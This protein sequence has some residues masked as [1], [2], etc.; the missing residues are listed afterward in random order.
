M[1][2]NDSPT[3]TLITQG[4]GAIRK[5]PNYTVPWT[6]QS[7]RVSD[8][9]F[10]FN[11]CQWLPPS[12]QT[13]MPPT[14]TSLSSPF[15]TSDRCQFSHHTIVV[16]FL[17]TLLPR[18]G[19]R[20]SE[21]NVADTTPYLGHPRH[22]LPTHLYLL[23][24]KNTCVLTFFSFLPSLLMHLTD[25]PTCGAVLLFAIFCTAHWRPS[26]FSPFLLLHSQT[27]YPPS[28][29]IDLIHRTHLL[30]QSSPS[31]YS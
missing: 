1:C 19:Q 18:L 10:L 31:L 4:P 22:S 7:G 29:V 21:S 20:C 23:L 11:A 26:T 9:R 5:P 12:T 6:Q 3:V 16:L 27:R 2:F 30:H 13:R 24:R 17:S 25:C 8:L 15:H 14:T 28:T